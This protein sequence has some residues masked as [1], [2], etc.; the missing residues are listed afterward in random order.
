MPTIKE[1]QKYVDNKHST[2][3]FFQTHLGAILDSLGITTDAARNAALVSLANLKLFD[4]KQR[5][6]GSRNISS[7]GVFG[8]IVRMNDKMER[9]KTLIST[10]RRKA[11]NESIS[12]SL[13]DISNYAIIATL[14][15][16]KRWPTV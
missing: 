8:V 13:T 15:D 1:I 2:D 6:Y 9:L 5:D 10:K 16:S 3:K 7:F 11:V 12:D 14:I 4:N